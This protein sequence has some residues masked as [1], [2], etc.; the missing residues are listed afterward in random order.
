MPKILVF[1][2]QPL[3]TRP[4]HEWLDNTADNIVLITTP[5]AV[6]GAEDVLAEHFPRHR[7]V[8][9]YHSWATEQAALEAA[10]EHGVDLVASTSESDVLR[11]ARLRVRLGLPGQHTESATAYRDK[12]VMKQLVQAAGLRVP[13]FAPI[14]DPL[15][16]LDFNAA[17]GFPLVVKPRF[18]AGSEDVAILRTMSDVTAFLGRQRESKVPYL[19]GQWMAESFVHADFF[20]VDGI[21]WDGRIVHAWPSQYSGGNAERV[22]DQTFLGSVLLAPD[23][24]RTSVLMRM[25]EKVIAALPAAPMPL[26]FHLEVWI[27]ED[28]VPVLCE[29][30]S[31]AGGALIAEAYE[32]VFGIQ[33]ARESLRAQCGSELALAYQPAAP[34]AATGWVLLPTGYGIFV[35]PV[36]P[37]PVPGAKLTLLLEAGTRRQ[38]LEH[39]T[40]AAASALVRADTA[41][42]VRKQMGELM[43]WWHAHTQW[44]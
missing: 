19:P 3:A 37:C 21:M 20:H 13:A 26:A 40:D 17:E 8:A 18:G 38:G 41:E 23:D 15:D 5:K 9:D 25:A 7:L 39:L 44:R 2:R 22:R 28:N 33:L 1:S 11:A 36:E 12:V 16:L 42:E 4:L 27:G 31:R 32:S 29:I 14:D 10:R 30:A 6:L 35:P 43:D 24:D 34:A